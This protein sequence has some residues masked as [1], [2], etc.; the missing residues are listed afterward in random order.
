MD[1]QRI[2]LLFGAA[3][4]SAALLSWFL[5]AK[6][7]GPR[8][9]KR[10]RVLVA[11]RDM[12]MGTLLKKSD[13]KLVAV[14]EA[15]VPKGALFSDNQAVN[16]VLLFPAYVNEPLL[17]T[18]VSSATS[19]EGVSSTIEPG[20]RAVSVQ[21]TDV[22]G[23]AG[24]VQPNSRV[25]VLFTRPGSMAEA[26]TSTILQNVKV[27]STGRI[28]QVGQTVDPKAPKMPVVTLVLTPADAQKLELAK[29]Q[30][31]ISLALRN[32]LDTGNAP[33]TGPVTTEVLDPMISARLARARRGRTTNVAR[34]NLED[35]KVWQELTGEK[36]PQDED[37]EKRRQQQEE[38]ARRKKE[39]E[40]PRVVVD[41]Y[42]GDKHVQEMFR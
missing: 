7:T 25:D 36:K 4:V 23:V 30:G 40:K 14:R 31:K 42:R 35:P 11:G 9:E 29:N 3:W 18:K 22:S 17:Q 10:I 6:T 37:K 15:D 41:V 27:L 5:Y 19:T 32:P 13:L 2:L 24:L 26:I 34:A 20:Y 21:I 1:R 16:R 12:P 38:E 8:E 39:S 33:E 28:T